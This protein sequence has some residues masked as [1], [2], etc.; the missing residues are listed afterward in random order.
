MDSILVAHGESRERDAM[1]ERLLAEGWRASASDNANTAP[2]WASRDPY[3]LAVI[4]LG[5]PPEKGFRAI[6]R[7]RRT[8]TRADLP[9]VAVGAPAY[10]APAL[11][12]GANDF[13]P[14]PVDVERLMARVQA[15]IDLRNLY[16]LKDEFFGIA[17]H[18][19]RAPLNLVLGY[20]SLLSDSLRKDAKPGSRAL[21]MAEKIQTQGTAMQRI[22]EEFLEFQALNGGYAALCQTP[23]DLN[24]IAKRIVESNMEYA[25]SKHIALSFEPDRSLGKVR[26]DC[27]RLEQVIHNF[28][29]NAIKFSPYGAEA[30]VSTHREASGAKLEVA[31]TGP[32]LKD[33]DFKNAFV[34]FARLSNKPTGNEKS[35][36]LGLAICKQLIEHHGGQIGVRNNVHGGATFWFR[37]PFAPR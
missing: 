18:D 5:D 15:Q 31:D 30:I 3:D 26:G 32:G 12:C 13:V 28:V 6:R 14:K 11:R 1:V 10:E 23:V 35:Y 20:A 22:I 24:R 34:K 8:L 21:M 27:G 2:D 9:I 17:S 16:R 4:D 36:G 29:N 25:A 19:L 37:L 7:L 33:S